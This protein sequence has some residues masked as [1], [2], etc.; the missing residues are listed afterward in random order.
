V[1]TFKMRP[2]GPEPLITVWA[3]LIPL[4]A[5]SMATAG[6]SVCSNLRERESESLH[7]PSSLPSLPRDQ[8][9]CAIAHAALYPPALSHFE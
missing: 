2:L 6:E 3:F 9:R 7:T 8:H 4:L 5:T 1:G